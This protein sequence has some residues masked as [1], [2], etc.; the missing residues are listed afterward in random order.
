MPATD[1]QL[2]FTSP[3]TDHIATFHTLT[4]Q[5]DTLAWGGSL[6]VC[7][8]PAS[9]K[10]VFSVAAMPSVPPAEKMGR[11]M[12]NCLF[13]PGAPKLEKAG[14]RS[15]MIAVALSENPTSHQ[16]ILFP[17]PYISR[18]PNNSK[19]AAFQPLKIVQAPVKV[20]QTYWYDVVS[21]TTGTLMMILLPTG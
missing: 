12:V 9:R 14:F 11:A 21:V 2:M 4:F 13:W 8:G 6:K 5:N 16:V 20:L 17:A 1:C 15:V 10:S 3:V 19:Q 18:S 7:F